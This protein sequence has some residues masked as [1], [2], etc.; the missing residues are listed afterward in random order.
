MAVPFEDKAWRVGAATQTPRAPAMRR[1]HVKTMRELLTVLAAALASSPVAANEHIVDI[2]WG[3]DGAF[4]HAASVAPGKFV[5]ACGKL[6]AGARIGWE[7]QA[8]AP[9]DFNIHYHRGKETVFPEKLQQVATANATLNVPVAEDY[10]WMWTN[11]GQ[12]PATVSWTLK[13]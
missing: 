9:I 1:L 11:K 12:S 5:E 13:R 6:A 8:D 4:R 2:V 3:A 10:C 7:F